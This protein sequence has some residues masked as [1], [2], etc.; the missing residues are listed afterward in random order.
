MVTHRPSAEHGDERWHE[1]DVLDASEM[2]A[3]IDR[4]GPT[5]LLHLAWC[6]GHGTFWED[7]ANEQ[8]AV[9]T[10]AIAEAFRAAGG[11]RFVLAGSCTQYEWT[12]EALAPDGVAR[13]HSTPMRPATAYGRAKQHTMDRLGTFGAASGLAVATGLVFFPYGPHEKEGRL[14]PSVTRALFAGEPARITSGT[15]IRD[16]VHVNDCAGALAAL[17]ASAVEGP[18]NIGSGEGVTVGEVARSI[19]RMLDRED[20]LEIGALPDRPGEPSRLV[21]DMTRLRDEVGFVAQVDLESGLRSTV[22]WWRQRTRRR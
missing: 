15:Q 9:A 3:L 8:W 10:L 17:T 14:I 7:P 1:I 6:T 18:V 5:H 4:V 16:F 11:E 19:A 22:D 21:A 13:E 2:Q 12:D 20:L